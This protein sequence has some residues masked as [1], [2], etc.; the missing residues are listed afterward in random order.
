MSRATSLRLSRSRSGP[1]ARITA[2]P[3]SSDC[4][5]SLFLGAV[6]ASSPRA[7]ALSPGAGARPRP[8]PA[9][10]TLARTSAWP[11]AAVESAAPSAAAFAA[12]S[13]DGA[14]GAELFAVRPEVLID[15]M[16]ARPGPDQNGPTHV[17]H[18]LVILLRL[19]TWLAGGAAGRGTAFHWLK[20]RVPLLCLPA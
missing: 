4:T 17:L 11:S 13:G 18:Q 3:R 1:N 10:G 19:I 5:K 12:T 9:A 8:P 6:A 7:G 20:L 2:S 15:R 16:L 14:G